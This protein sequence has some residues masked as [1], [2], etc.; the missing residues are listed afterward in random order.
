[1]VGYGARTFAFA[2][3]ASMMAGT[4]WLLSLPSQ[5]IVGDMGQ[6]L[7]LM[8]TLAGGILL[9]LAALTL[10]IPARTVNA[11]YT[12]SENL[13]TLLIACAALYPIAD[14]DAGELACLAVNPEY[15]HGGAATSCSSSG[16]PA[17]S[18]TCDRG[19]PGATWTRSPSSAR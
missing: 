10:M 9:A 15:R 12:L 17:A 18:S 7:V 5:I 8:S 1:M 16:S 14:S 3:A 13:L 19:K 2:T 4:W 6:A 11:D